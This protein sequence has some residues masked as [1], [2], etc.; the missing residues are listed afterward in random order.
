MNRTI[1]FGAL[2]LAL[3]FGGASGALAASKKHNSA[4]EAYAAS[5]AEKVTDPRVN[6]GSNHEGWCDMDAQCNGWGEWLRD[7][8]EGKLKAQ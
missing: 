2:S 5:G 6:K 7:V 3:V 8:E 4:H 1:A